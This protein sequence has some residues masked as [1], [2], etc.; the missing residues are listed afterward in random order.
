VQPISVSSGLER[1]VTSCAAGHYECPEDSGNAVVLIDCSENEEGKLQCLYGEASSRVLDGSLGTIATE[2]GLSAPPAIDVCTYDL[3]SGQLD[4]ATSTACHPSAVVRTAYSVPGD[5]P[6]SIGKR[7]HISKHPNPHTPTG[8]LKRTHRIAEAYHNLKAR[9][10]GGF[11]K[12][13]ANNYTTHNNLTSSDSAD[14]AT[15]FTDHGF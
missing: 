14:N 3:L 5:T 11:T 8:N 13:N 6:G 7:Y 12:R 9:P 15:T 1:S 10:V 4:L 2:N